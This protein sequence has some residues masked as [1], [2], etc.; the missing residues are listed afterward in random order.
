MAV[1]IMNTAIKMQLSPIRPM[2]RISIEAAQTLNTSHSST[3]HSV[4]P[5]S[6]KTSPIGVEMLSV[7]VDC[8]QTK[9]YL[10]KTENRVQLLRNR[11]QLL[12]QAVE[13]TNRSTREAFRT[14]SVKTETELMKTTLK[15]LEQE[16]LKSL[17]TH[18]FESR[19]EHRR[20]WT[21]YKEALLMQKRSE[22]KRCKRELEQ[23]NALAKEKAIR[24]QEKNAAKRITIQAERKVA[25][26]HRDLNL[27]HRTEQLRSSYLNRMDKKR[28]T[29]QECI[30]RVSCSQLKALEL[31]ET[32]LIEALRNSWKQHSSAQER[33]KA[34]TGCYRPQSQSDQT[35][36]SPPR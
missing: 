4:S 27:A 13:D 16:Q 17:K 3:R 36:K 1:L 2:S 26:M 35:P 9:E 11:K 6:Y 21:I 28:A 20:R 24:E 30:D 8:K 15:E 23:F 33:L 10:T 14:K 31:E 18:R 25:K 7:I 32:Q 34:I 29:K 22:A 12:D 19:H 5:N